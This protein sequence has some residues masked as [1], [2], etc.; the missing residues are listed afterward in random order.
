MAVGLGR[1]KTEAY[2]SWVTT[3]NVAVAC[4]N[5]QNSV[6]ASGDMSAIEELERLLVKD[7]VF[8]RRLRI[9]GAFH[10]IHMSPISEMYM[11]EL[12]TLLRPKPEAATSSVVFSSS[13]TGGRLDNLTLLATPE[14]WNANMLGVVEFEASFRRMCF[15]MPSPEKSRSSQDVD[16]V[17][18]VG[19]HGSLGGPM[20]DIMTLP[21]FDG[22]TIS[23]LNCLVRRKNSVDTMQALACGLLRKGYPVNLRAVNFPDGVWNA[24]VISN[25]PSYPWTHSTGFWLEPRSNRAWRQRTSSSHDLLGTYQLSSNSYTPSW[26]N[27]LRTSELPWLRDHVVSSNVVYPGAG[28]ICMAIEAATMLSLQKGGVEDI[29]GYSLRD[30]QFVNALVIPEGAE[31]REVQLTISPCSERSL[32][33]RGWQ[34]FRVYSVTADNKWSEHCH[35][36]IQVDLRTNNAHS[37]LDNPPSTPMWAKKNTAPATYTRQVDPEDMWM[38]MRSVGIC[39]G[40]MFRNLTEVISNRDESV[41]TFC[42]TDVSAV[43][44]MRHQSEYLIHPTTLDSVF[45]TA[46]SALPGLGTRLVSPFVPRSIKHLRLGRH[47]N[48]SPGHH[49]RTHIPRCISLNPRSFQTDITVFDADDSSRNAILEIKGLACQ[50]LDGGASRAGNSQSDSGTCAS[51]R[52]GLDLS[53]ETPVH[54][55]DHLKRPSKAEDVE[56]TM[57]LRRAVLN[58]IQDTVSS[59]TKADIQNLEW[60]HAKHYQWMQTQLTLAADNKLGPDSSQWLTS[61]PE[62]RM[63]LVNEIA[64]TSVNGEMLQRVGPRIPSI[65]K[66]EVTPLEL[67]LEGGLLFRFYVHALKYD[68]STQQMAEL[69]KILAHKSPRAKI[70]EIGA[71]TGGGTQA[72]LSALGRDQDGEAALFKHYDFTDVSPG[73]FEAARKRFEDWS[74][75]MTF[76]KLD[77]ETDAAEQGFECGS[78]DIV[79]ACQCLH[80]TRSMENTMKNVRRL[81]KPGGRLVLLETTQDSLDVFLTF[82]LLPGWWLSMSKSVFF[83]T[84]VRDS[85]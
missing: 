82:G 4:V 67:M 23:Y 70:L 78:Y 8:C 51:V 65:L 42:V 55:L 66:R 5:S 20:Q 53:F 44:P 73:F 19:P 37:N 85:D 36:L 17:L 21:D 16:I 71:G 10:S 52:W 60:H 27:V 29:L 41:V 72:V 81:L 83:A 50:S 15:S 74:D 34:E 47:I 31:G 64:A 45:Q 33:A 46:Y 49:F 39:H 59:L 75:L 13:M 56:T 84:A 69:V 68:T 54:A 28:Y 1:E 12:R 63:A 18:E 30:V 25:L 32:G 22:T 79:I 58:Y 24:R 3:G 40:P 7:K 57:K 35:G 2:I 61:T 11:T 14:Y 76:R 77:I 62:E 6:T 26:R 38:A 9:N 80:A 43:M 48:N